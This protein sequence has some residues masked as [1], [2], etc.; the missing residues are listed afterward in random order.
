[1][2]LTT[3]ISFCLAA[4]CAHAQE[5]QTFDMPTGVVHPINA[6]LGSASLI[7]LP[8]EPLATNIGD[9]EMW[10][11]EKAD[12]LVSIKPVQAGIR[13]TSLAIVT[14]QGTLNFALHLAPDSEQFTQMA[15]ITK[16]LDDAKPAAPLSQSAG[17]ETLADVIIREIR[18][19]QNFYAL[20]SVNSPDLRDVEQFTQ[21]IT[22]APFCKPSGSGT[23]AISSFISPPKTARPFP[24]RLPTDK[25]RSM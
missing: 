19:A 18:I 14:R 4:F 8:V 13:D 12:K 25:R 3:F 7:Q 22:L 20:S 24:C 6:R 15:R 11:V 21:L 2:R 10:K 9:P 23:H 16:I 17:Q 5:V 1:M